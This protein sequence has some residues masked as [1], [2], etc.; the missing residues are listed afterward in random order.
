MGISGLLVGLAVGVILQRG[1][2][3]LSGHLRNMV[4]QRNLSSFAPL[5]IAIAIQSVGFFILEQQGAIRFPASSMPIVATL[6]G[7]LLFGIGMGVSNRCVS[8]QLY[9]SGEGMLAALTTLIVFALTTTA[10][11]T[12]MLKFYTAD[13]LASES[14][15]V[16]IQQTLGVS[17]LYLIIPFCLFTLFVAIKTRPTQFIPKHLFKGTWSGHF[18]AVMLAFA[19]ILAWYLSAQTGREF[20]LSFSIPLGNAVQYVVLGQQRYLNWGTY[21]I[22]GVVIGSFCSAWLS[23][24]LKWRGVSPLDY[25]KSTAGGILMGLGAALA[26]G[27]TM[28]NAVVGTAYFSWQAWIATLMMMF[29]CWCVFILRKNPLEKT[30]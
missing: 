17:S 3:C 15:F 1:Q 7:G 29:G 2:F 13:L 26:G 20:G 18:T 10:T 30:C 28:A 4:F 9:R 8:G 12:G 27:C 19:S 6:V 23:S 16:T 14:Q 11:Q 21:L 24:E 5:L 25:A 22:F